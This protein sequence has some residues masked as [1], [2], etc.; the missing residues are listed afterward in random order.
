MYML[1]LFEEGD[2]Q[3][4]DA[5]LLRDGSLSIGRDGSCDWPIVDPDRMISRAHCEIAPAL[6]GLIVRPLGAN[7]V[8]DDST[9]DRLPDLVDVPVTVPF[10][11]RMGRFRIAATRT[12]LDDSPED[13]TRTMVLTPPLGGSTRVPT[14][15]SDAPAPLPGSEEGS[16]LEAFCRG[17]GLDAS[18][19]SSEDPAEIMQRAGAVYRQMVLGIGDLMAERDRA[20]GRYSLARTTI[21]GTG[22][23]PFKWAPTQR[24]AID[25]LLSGASGFLSGS[26]AISTSFQDI[27]RHLIA[28]FAGLQ[29]SLRCA[30][31]S[32]SP[33]AL[34]DAAGKGGLLQNRAARQVQAAA[35][36]HADLTRQLSEGT[37]GSLDQAFVKAYDAA[38]QRTRDGG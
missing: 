20:R 6:D 8:F 19:L 36:R 24:L 25:L 4:I 18:L 5:R 27:K 30:V 1:Q 15:W 2:A 37:S 9:G 10:T 35:T 33:A 23:N 31:D 14:D 16:L 29:G 11:L 32:F 26:A 3:P 34:S 38:E 22:N 13:V 17:A 28:T 12:M 21:G 7:G